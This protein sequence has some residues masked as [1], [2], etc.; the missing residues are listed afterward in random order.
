MSKYTFSRKMCVRALRCLGFVLDN[1]RSGKHDKYKAPFLGVNPPFIMLP[2]H[3]TLHCQD[4]IVRELEKMG[5]EELIKKFEQ[6]L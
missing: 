2:R 3:N 4:A 1:K 5:G 6:F